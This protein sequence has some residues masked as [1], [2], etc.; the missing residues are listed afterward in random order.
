MSQVQL[1]IKTIDEKYA[2]LTD[3][4]NSGHNVLERNGTKNKKDLTLELKIM[5]IGG[6][7]NK[8]K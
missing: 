6:R 3:K 2:T 4:Q 7:L 5:A 8:G 1:S